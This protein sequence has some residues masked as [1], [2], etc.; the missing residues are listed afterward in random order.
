MVAKG[1]DATNP[2]FRSGI[3]VAPCS[4][5]AAERY[6]NESTKNLCTTTVSFNGTAGSF[7]PESSDDTSLKDLALQKLKNR[8]RSYT[9]Q[10]RGLIPLAEIRD[11]ERS[12]MG[13][14]NFSSFGVRNLASMLKGKKLTRKLRKDLLSEWWL[15]F[16]F[17]LAPIARDISDLVQAI[18]NFKNNRTETSERFTGK[19]EKQWQ[20]GTYATTSGTYYSNIRVTKMHIHKLS[21]KYIAGYDV[22]ILTGNDY[23]LDDHL[24]LGPNNI[25]ATLWEAAPYSWLIDYLT[26]VGA[27]LDD[28][29]EFPPSSSKY[30]VLNKRYTCSVRLIPSLDTSRPVQKTSEI[31]IEGFIEYYQFTRSKLSSLPKVG[32]HFNYADQMAKYGF[33]KLINLL[34]VMQVGWKQ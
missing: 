14:L 2:Y 32:L 22:T 10:Y 16:S 29:W 21:Y 7:S 13:L 27:Y 8:L 23:S 34:A 28:T 5:S 25:P 3:I 11:L 15:G 31:P 12:A 24:G 20:S 30:L 26:N 19:A 6:Y 4:L 18:E 33:T 9:G 17:G 1:Q